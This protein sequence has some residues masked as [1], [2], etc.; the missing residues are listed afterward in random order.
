MN[1][2]IRIGAIKPYPNINFSYATKYTE[3][4]YFQANLDDLVDNC[5]ESMHLYLD[6]KYDDKELNMFIRDGVKVY[7]DINNISAKSISDDN[8]VQKV[9]Y[10]DLDL[11][12]WMKDI[13]LCLKKL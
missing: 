4:Q 1:L 13:K 10:G 11:P 8:E 12:K 2:K 6:P 9:V 5:T 7:K 3:L